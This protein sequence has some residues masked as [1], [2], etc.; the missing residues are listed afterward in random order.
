VTNTSLAQR[1]LI[2]ATKRLR[3]LHVLLD[4]EAYSDVVCEAQEVVEQS[5]LRKI[6][7]AFK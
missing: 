3:I 1:Y 7:Q 5:R 2:K 6:G 4:D